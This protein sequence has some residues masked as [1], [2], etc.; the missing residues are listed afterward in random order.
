MKIP[1]RFRAGR[2]QESQC[3]T[4]ETRFEK[5]TLDVP[6]TSEGIHVCTTGLHVHVSTPTGKGTHTHIHVHIHTRTHTYTSTHVRTH[7]YQVNRS[8]EDIDKI[9]REEGA[10]C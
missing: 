1:T 7:I 4:K 10:C 8:I 3:N 9:Q 6:F 5:Y 2:S